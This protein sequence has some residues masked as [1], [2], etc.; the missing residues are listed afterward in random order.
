LPPQEDETNLKQFAAQSQTMWAVIRPVQDILF[1]RWGHGT[2][3][4]VFNCA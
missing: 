3:W 4:T 1:G 2:V